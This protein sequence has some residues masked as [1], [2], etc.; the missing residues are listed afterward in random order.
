[1]KKTIVAA[2]LGGLSAFCLSTPGHATGG[3]WCST[4]DKKTTISVGLGRVP[5]YAPFNAIIE[6]GDKYWMTEPKDDAIALGGTQGMIEKD[7]LAMDFTDH[8]VTEIIIS[9]RVSYADEDGEGYYSG[10]LT[11]KGHPTY[12]VKCEF[13]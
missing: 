3:V 11:I 2:I 9:L 6:S 1:M 13:E 7:R 8:D 12:D 5:I 10:K 4:P